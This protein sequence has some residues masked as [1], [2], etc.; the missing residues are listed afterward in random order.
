MVKEFAIALTSC[1]CKL[2]EI[3]IKNSSKALS[4]KKKANLASA[5]ENLALTIS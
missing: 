5:R 1:F 3:L 4:A 2:Y